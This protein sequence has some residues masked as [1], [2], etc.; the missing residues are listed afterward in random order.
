MCQN[1]PAAIGAVWRLDVIRDVQVFEQVVGKFVQ[2][3]QVVVSVKIDLQEMDV[4]G[5]MEQRGLDVAAIVLY[6]PGVIG[7][8]LAITATAVR[9]SRLSW[10]RHMRRTRR[11]SF[12]TT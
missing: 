4:G 3:V 6:I 8:Q 7:E 5:E 2:V 10:T 12:H 1:S 11:L 9:R